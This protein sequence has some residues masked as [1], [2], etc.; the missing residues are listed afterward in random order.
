[1]I[2]LMALLACGKPETFTEVQDDILSKS[3]ALSSCHG[4]GAGHL[5]L[6]EGHAYD[7][8]VGVTPAG[9]NS[10]NPDYPAD[11]DVSDE[12]LVIP[13]DSANSYLI[14]KLTGAP[15]INGSP[16]PDGSTGFDPEKVAQIAEWIDDGAQDD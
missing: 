10:T 15:D 1:M 13:N 5:D 8:L 7:S 16:M 3:C 9:V 4:G 11:V 6:T 12:I 14:K 2:L